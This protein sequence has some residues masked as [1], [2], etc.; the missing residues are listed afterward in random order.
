MTWNVL[1]GPRYLPAGFSI[2]G[3]IYAS[4]GFQINLSMSQISETTFII[5]DPKEK[6]NCNSVFI[7]LHE[8]PWCLENHSVSIILKG[9]LI[10]KARIN[11]KIKENK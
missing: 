5:W 1:I 11:H 10:K 7:L 6:M 2:V 4:S 8:E 3:M 9:E